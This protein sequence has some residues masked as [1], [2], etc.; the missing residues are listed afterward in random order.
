MNDLPRLSGRAFLRSEMRQA[1]ARHL[2]TGLSETPVR[3]WALST[4]D[5]VMKKRIAIAL[6]AGL[7]MAGV[8]VASATEMQQS[9]GAKM[10]PQHN[11]YAGHKNAGSNNVTSNNVTKG[12]QH[13]ALGRAPRHNVD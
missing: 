6:A 7:L 9:V 11:V 1:A 2:T 8:S 13:A 3:A 12:H 4:G 5:I 10:S